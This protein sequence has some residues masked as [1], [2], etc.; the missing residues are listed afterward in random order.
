MFKD[1]ETLSDTIEKIKHTLPLDFDYIKYLEYNPDLSVNGI[2]TEELA[3]HHYLLFGINE[4][5]V[6]KQISLIDTIDN[7][8][9]PEFYL[10][11]YPDVQS[12]YRSV[13]G[14][15][16]KKNYSITIFTM[17]KMKEDSRIKQNKIGL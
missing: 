12:Y 2:N 3:K 7:N 17:E 6:Y 4:Q 13:D 14:I 5:R 15:S 9:D 11:E 10:S 1:K 16:Q 8:F